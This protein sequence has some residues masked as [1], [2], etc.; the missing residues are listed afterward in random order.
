VERWKASVTAGD[1][2]ASL[3]ALLNRQG[4]AA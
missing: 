1:P 3:E 2:I 4:S